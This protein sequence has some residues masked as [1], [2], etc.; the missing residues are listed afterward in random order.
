MNRFQVKAGDLKPLP[1]VQVLNAD[2]S[3]ADLS[4][5]SEIIFRMTPT[6]PGLRSDVTGVA[7]LPLDDDPSTVEYQWLAGDTDVPGLY[8][9]EYSGVYSDTQETYPTDGYISIEI[10]R[11]AVAPA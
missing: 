5:A 1:R 6:T 9:A 7:T 2:G 3:P 8:E 10:Q 11:R 4:G